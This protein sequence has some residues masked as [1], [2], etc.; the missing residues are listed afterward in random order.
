MEIVL[1][2]KKLER[3]EGVGGLGDK[4]GDMNHISIETM[5]TKKKRKRVR[6]NKEKKV[7]YISKDSL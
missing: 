5:L 3:G 4:C 7:H 1:R 2:E 6:G